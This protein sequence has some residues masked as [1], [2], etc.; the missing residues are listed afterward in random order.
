V[1]LEIKND[2]VDY[3]VIDPSSVYRG[4]TY[5][6]WLTD[7][8]NWLIS[9]DPDKH[10][11][12]P[13][14]FL[15]ANLIPSSKS[16]SSEPTREIISDVSN[17]YSD[18]P[19]YPKRYA[20]NPNVRVGSD[21][22]Q[23][24]SDQAIFVPIITAYAEASKPYDDW[25]TL[26]DYTGAAIDNGDNPPSDDQLVIDGKNLELPQLMEDNKR[27]REVF[28]KFRIVTPLFTAVFPETDYGRSLKDMLEMNVS[29]G[30]YPTIVEGYVV[31]IK[32][33]LVKE[34]QKT[35][36]I[37]SMASAGHET[38]GFYFAELLYEIEVLK[39]EGAGI[40]GAPGFRPAENKGIIEQIFS[41]KVKNGELTAGDIT[42]IKSNIN[43]QYKGRAI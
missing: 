30:H 21:K 14:V 35:H 39:R 28:K 15:R 17:T 20:N 13:V 2:M 6:D 8:Y 32:F 11:S 7:W 40:D 41:E 42:R 36:Y 4:K 24:F 1:F 33:K 29:A 25:G 34:D 5:S 27:V 37:H 18:D 26:Q 31:M 22:L 10:N 38:R 23:V 9:T 12:G 43:K 16:S 3:D 19:Y